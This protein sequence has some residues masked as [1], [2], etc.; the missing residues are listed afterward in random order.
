M[1][2]D[3]WWVVGGMWYVVCGLHMGLNVADSSC[4]VY[5]VGLVRLT[6]GV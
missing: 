2:V 4:M 3:V 5:E 6:A 1:D